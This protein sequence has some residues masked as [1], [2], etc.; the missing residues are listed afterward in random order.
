MYTVRVADNFHMRDDAETYTLGTFATL[1]EAEAAA[2]GVVDGFLVGQVRPGM[3]A[4]AL[5]SLY[6]GFGS[7]PYILAE[8]GTPPPPVRFAGWEYARARCG[9]LCAARPPDDA[10]A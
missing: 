6:S 5:Y 9:E 3:T 10:T 4:D 1:A 7:E 8:P 2:R